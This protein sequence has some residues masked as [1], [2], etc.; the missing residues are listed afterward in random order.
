MILEFIKMKNYRQ[1]VNQQID[2][3]VSEKKRFIAIEGST[4]TGKTNLLNAVT[5]C[6]YGREPYLGKKDRGYPIMNVMVFGSMKPTSTAEVEVEVKLNKGDRQYTIKRTQ[7][8]K[9]TQDGKIHILKLG[10]QRDGTKL[11]VWVHDYPKVYY[12]K[13]MPSRV[14]QRLVPEDIHEYFFFDGERL[15]IYLK[16]EGGEK[17]REAVFKI[18]Q[19]QLLDRVINHLDSM[20]RELVRK[21]TVVST[22][23]HDLNEQIE[24]LNNSLISN[25][26]S[27]QDLIRNQK[28]GERNAND[29]RNQLMKSQVSDVQELAIERDRKVQEID[30]LKKQLMELES[31]CSSFVINRSSKILAYDA[32]RQLWKR[33]SERKEAGELPPDIKRNFLKALLEQGQCICGT[34]IT[35]DTA[36]RKNVKK[37]LNECDEITDISGELIRLRID[38]E[39][40][41]NEVK[42]YSDKYIT[43]CKQLKGVRNSIKSSSERVKEIEDKIK[44]IDIVQIR[45]LEE[46][47][48]EYNKKLIQ[49]TELIGIKK[50]T[51]KNT[52]KKI[53][54]LENQL[55]SEI[56]KEKKVE[57]LQHQRKLCE[58]TL[59]LAQKVKDEIM[60]ECRRSI[61]LKTK[62]RFQ[63][64]GW[65]KKSYTN[66]TLDR[67]YGISLKDESGFDAVGTLSAGER[68]LLTLAFIEPL[69]DIS[70]FDVPIIIDTPFGRIADLP[71][72]NIAKHLPN[73]FKGKQVILLVTDKEYELVVRKELSKVM[74]K[75]YRISFTETPPAGGVAEVLPYEK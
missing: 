9:K 10:N 23:T 29:I 19:L 2:L 41:M 74:H 12:Y 46:R 33:I 37:L 36:F 31:E 52:K 28:E 65:K 43:Y 40:I 55:D 11:E 42:G 75:E 24:V 35:N 51:I 13:D 66:L 67:N 3:G 72:E 71:T 18:S 21:S 34:D 62:Q 14:V 56:K 26:E 16:K 20:K 8:I 25:N 70:G 6:L 44:G 48:E 39:S 15:D 32:V 63:E 27:L 53:E 64:M 50:S 30:T 38:L 1:Y 58:T 57:S 5:W 60:E 22:K 59:N 17:I 54:E 47:L 7:W 49:V 4:G 61:E 73:Y 45:R 69:N 68:Q